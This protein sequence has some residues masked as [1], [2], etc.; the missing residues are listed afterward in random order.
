M[1]V[2]LAFWVHVRLIFQTFLF[3]E[4]RPSLLPV[5][6]ESDRDALSRQQRAPRAKQSWHQ[7]SSWGRAGWRRS[8]A[9]LTAETPPWGPGPGPAQCG[10]RRPVHAE[11]VTAETV[12]E[13]SMERGESCSSLAGNELDLFASLQ[14]VLSRIRL[15]SLPWGKGEGMAF[16]SV[17]SAAPPRN[18]L[19]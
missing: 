19:S 6:R 15:S 3:L 17:R 18:A 13:F 10:R 14:R 11:A 4:S 7:P 9:A 5:S 1:N 16:Y 12:V 8:A 2:Y